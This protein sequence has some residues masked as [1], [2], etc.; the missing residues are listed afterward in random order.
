MTVYTGLTK[1]NGYG[2]GN[3]PARVFGEV[4]DNLWA[5][6]SDWGN[7][8]HNRAKMPKMRAEYIGTRKGGGPV[9]D[10]R[11]MG[12]KDAIY[13][14]ENNGYKCQYEGIGHVVSQIPAAGTQCK[15]G[16]TVK[17]VLK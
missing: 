17:L 8:I 11:D 9:P 15:K 1:S 14:L 3:H 2:G 16:E 5:L 10:V 13:A 7:T 4:V 12:L 6:D